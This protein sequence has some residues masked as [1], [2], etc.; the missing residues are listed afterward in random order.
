VIHQNAPHHLST[1]RKEVQPVLALNAMR[2]NQL[3]VRLVGQR[4]GIKAVMGR[5]PE[6]VQ[7]GKPAQFGIDKGNQTL[8]RFFV[9]LAPFREQPG[10]I[11]RIFDWHHPCELYY[12]IPI[13]CLCPAGRDSAGEVKQRLD[14]Q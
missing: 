4:S 8:Q 5:P 6:Q 9:A 2:P 11:S 10:D 12:E 13:N 1:Q 7:T 14:P 3:E